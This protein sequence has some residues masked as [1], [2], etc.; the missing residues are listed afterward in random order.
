MSHKKDRGSGA[1]V[2]FFG[3]DLVV[4]SGRVDFAAEDSVDRQG[5][6]DDEGHSE[7]GDRRHRR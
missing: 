6:G 1:S 2:H 5:V 4:E 3:R 7:E